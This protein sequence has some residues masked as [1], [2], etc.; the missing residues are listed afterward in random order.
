MHYMHY[1]DYIHHDFY[2]YPPVLLTQYLGH[3]GHT[4]CT[5]LYILRIRCITSLAAEKTPSPA[6]G[7]G[8]TIWLGGVWGSLLIYIYI[9]IYTLDYQRLIVSTLIHGKLR[10]FVLFV[11]F[12]LRK[13]L[14]IY[15]YIY[16]YIHQI[17]VSQLHNP[18][19]RRPIGQHQDTRCRSSHHT[20]NFGPELMICLTSTNIYKLGS[21]KSSTITVSNIF[22]VC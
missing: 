5:E 13:T 18:Q 16:I 6:T 9:Y 1:K 8:G 20:D 4:P 10:E 17:Y 14:N 11:S 15:R 21:D 2:V 22:Y 12:C 3:C 19:L 7:G